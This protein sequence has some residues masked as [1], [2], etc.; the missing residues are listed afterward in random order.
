MLS[1]DQMEFQKAIEDRLQQYLPNEGKLQE[2]L[3]ESMRYS[4]LDGGKRIRPIL[5]LEFCRLCGGDV[6]LALPFACAVEMIH[7]YSLIHDDL[8]CMDNDDMRRGKPSNHKAYGEDT[9]LLAGD[10]LLT[11][12]FEVMLSPETI[13]LVGAEKCAAAAGI[14]ARMAGAHGMVGG[15]VIDLM[16]EGQTI[17]LE[18]LQQM[19]AHKTGALIVAACQMG[20]VVGGAGQELLDAAQKYAEAI[21]LAF[22]IVDDILDVTSSEEMLGKPIGS[23]A[24]NKKNTYVTLLG[25]EKAKQQAENL[26][27]Q[28]VSALSAFSGDTGP[29]ADLAYMLAKRNK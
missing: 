23:D 4:L 25:L 11:M 26:T 2:S 15:Q 16:S 19:D 6:R 8:P 13:A 10:A 1:P 3:F 29:L 20:C 9:A 17:S 24:E 12:A 18:T 14:L 7:T 21:G 22:Q 27:G 28:A 5:T